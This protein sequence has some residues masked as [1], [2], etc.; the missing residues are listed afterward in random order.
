MMGLL[1]MVGFLVVFWG[2]VVLIILSAL[3]IISLSVFSILL[4]SFVCLCIIIVLMFVWIRNEEAK[5]RSDT[6]PSDS[7]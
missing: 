2:T 5:E 4:A 1:I 3:G 7:P 6:S